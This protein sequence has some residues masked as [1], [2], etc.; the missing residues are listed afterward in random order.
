MEIVVVRHGEPD[1]E[2]GGRA[3][4]DPELTPLGHEQ[5]ARVAETLGEEH[6]DGFYV[7]PLR[8]AR[9]TAAP[10]AKRLGREPQVES[11]LRE[12]RLPEMQG[13]TSDEVQQFFR[14]ARARELEKW[15]DGMAGGE[16]FRHMHERVSAGVEGLLIGDHA[17]RI[18]EDSGHRIWARPEATRRLL[19]VAHEGTNAVILSHLLGIAP[20]PWEWMR[21]SSAWAGISRLR[22]AEVASGAIWVLDAF[23]RI[24]HLKGLA[25]L[26][27]G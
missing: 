20:V 14:A 2:P 22:G 17:M 21:F 11:W 12:I 4:D 16:S 5:A 7:S 18:H 23:N 10:I 25:K 6:F 1:W 19:I 15:W 26:G 27:E 9:E 24:H 3:M 13:K 8:R